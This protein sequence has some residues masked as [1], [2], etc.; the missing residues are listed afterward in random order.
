MYANVYIYTHCERTGHLAKFCYDRI[1][2]TNFANKFSWVR[3]CAN[4]HGSKKIWVPKF[5]PISVVVG[6]GSHMT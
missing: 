1:H 4:P 2:A 6:V 5:I 3:K